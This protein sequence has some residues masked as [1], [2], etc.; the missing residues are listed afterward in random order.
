[1]PGPNGQNNYFHE[2]K[3]QP[4]ILVWQRNHDPRLLTEI[5]QGCHEL[6]RVVILLNK[7]QEEMEYDDLYQEAAM[8][9]VHA[10][11]RYNPARGRAYS[12]LL[13]VV[14]NRCLQQVQSCER[15]RRRETCWEP[16]DIARKGSVN[17]KYPTEFWERLSKFET[18]FGEPV[19]LEIQ[20]RILQHLLRYAGTFFFRRGRLIDE[21]YRENHQLNGKRVRQDQLEFLF[22]YVLVKL[23]MLLLENCPPP[24]LSR[25]QNAKMAELF[26]AIGPEAYSKLVWV[27]GDVSPELK[28]AR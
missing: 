18:R 24:L 17:P 25:P 19:L 11:P 27:F 23:R 12:F 7:F 13:T 1:M 21:L 9:I 3:V 14:T 2:E 10:L 5:M 15:R 4:L 20:R 6:I 28:N 8:R 26:A 22:C 16:Q